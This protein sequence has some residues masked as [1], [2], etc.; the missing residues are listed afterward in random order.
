MATA[1]RPTARPARTATPPTT[2]EASLR[3]LRRFHRLGS[4]SAPELDPPAPD[5]LPALLHPYREP[6]RVRDETPLLLRPP[7]GGDGPPVQVLAGA[8]EDGL[9]AIAPD[10]GQARV[11]RDNRLRIERTLRARASERP[12]LDARDELVAAAERAA[13]DLGLSE[14]HGRTLVADATRL[15]EHLPEG[16]VLAGDRPDLALRIVIH[17]ARA[18][19]V[20]RREALALDATRLAGHLDDLLRLD[21]G[22]QAGGRSASELGEG[23]GRVGSRFLDPAA[24]SSTLGEWKGAGAMPADRRA[25]IESIADTL[26]GFVARGAGPAVT[27]IRPEASTPLDALP[28]DVEVVEHDAPLDEAVRRFDARCAELTGVFRAL[29]VARMELDGVYDPDRHDAWV[30][31][32]DWRSF[33]RDERLLLPP[34]VAVHHADRVATGDLAALSRTLRS[35][36][37]VHVV[38]ETTPIPVDDPDAAGQG[39]L[40]LGY[41]AIGHRDAVVHQSTSARP[42]HLV[43]GVE[44]AL[45][46][47]RPSLHLLAVGARSD[48]TESVVGRWLHVGAAIEARAHPLFLY[49]PDAGTT[50][51]RRL[52]FAGNPAPD[53]DWPSAP[54]DDAG[55]GEPRSAAFT[56]G[57]LALLEPGLRPWFAKVPSVDGLDDADDLVPLHELLATDPADAIHR[58]PV[59]I[60]VDREGQRHRLAVT[61]RLVDACRDRLDFWRTLQELAGVRNAYVAEATERL[62]AEMNEA[63]GDERARLEADRDQ[64]VA[65]ARDGAAREAMGALA[66]MLLDLDPGGALLAAPPGAAR[67]VAA[68]P[69][70]SAPSAPTTAP[71]EEDP[72]LAESPTDAPAPDDA[73]DDDGGFDDPWI[74]TPRCTS[75]NDCMN[76]NA[77]TFVYD[78]NKQARIGDASAA[79]FEELVRAAELCPAKCIHPGK[80]KNPDEPGLEDLLERAAPFNG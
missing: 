15:A 6:G 45:G 7:G 50:W 49:D 39:H 36:R 38:L 17:L 51:A 75:C 23:M 31:G 19:A 47:A 1:N 66:R 52:E 73:D 37:P 63:L 55:D 9:A 5:V 78:E 20:R 22:K 43:R 72:S 26:R 10:P 2:V 80:P 8:I 33:S 56:Y 57:D 60:G 41:L 14:E 68:A 64:A 70:P 69:A 79:T 18:G 13:T 44:V 77:L 54:V 21:R 32:Y 4:A 12:G 35:R 16:T 24:L 40:E 11:L 71:D 34:V 61:D 46:S 48:G 27:V 74:D 62:R 42:D 25:R 76:V 30:Q 58:I 28:P 3:A 67:A 29:H 59:V 65:E 53:A